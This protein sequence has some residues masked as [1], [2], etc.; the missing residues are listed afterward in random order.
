MLA[1]CFGGTKW[2]IFELKG[3]ETAICNTS[4]LMNDF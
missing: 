2:L 1:H 4:L 3:Y